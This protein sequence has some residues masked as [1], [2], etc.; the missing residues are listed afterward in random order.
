VGHDAH[1]GGALVGLYTTAALHPHI[2]TASPKLFAG[3]S[4]GTILLFLYLAKNPLFLPAGSIPFRKAG[5]ME[6][7]AGLPEYKLRERQIDAILAKISEKGI[8]SLTAEEEAVL[9]D[10]SDKQRRR[11]KSE[12]PKSGLTI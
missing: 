11:A 3:I 6:E 8:Q 10:A 9:R 4:I 7:R 1:L 5:K 2:I 12:K